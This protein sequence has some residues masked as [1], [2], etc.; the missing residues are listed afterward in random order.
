MPVN[1]FDNY[2][3]AWK[4][5]KSKLSR[6]IYKALAEQMER[7][8]ADGLL[9]PGTKLPPQRELADFL[10]I[11][12]TTVTRA[13]KLCEYKGLIYSV[14]GS[15]TFVSARTAHDASLGGKV[16]RSNVIELG[17][18]ISF[19]ETNMDVIP[20]MH[21]VLAHKY[22]E[23]LLTYREPY[24][25]A[26]QRQAASEWL[27]LLGVNVNY[28]D[29]AIMN[30]ALNAVATTYLTLFNSGERIAVDTFTYSNFIELS[31]LFHLTLVP[32]RSDEQGMSADD[33]EAVCRQTD[34]RGLFLIPSCANPTTTVMSE[35]RKKDIAKVIKKYDLLLIEDDPEAFMTYGYVD[36][37][38]EPLYSMVPDNTIYICSMSKSFCAGVRIAFMIAPPKAQS[39]LELSIFNTNVKTSSLDA[40]IV[41]EAIMTGRAHKMC[42]KRI[43]LAKQANRIYEEIFP[44]APRPGH[45]NPYYRWHPVS[46]IISHSDKDSSDIEKTLLAHGVSVFPSSIYKTDSKAKDDHIRISL[47]SAGSMDK[48]K[49]GLTIVRDVLSNHRPE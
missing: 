23:Q 41:T 14:M 6:P 5:E 48:L 25:M 45:P 36:G 33:L 27:S 46:D 24:G 18:V 22:P 15:G 30:G 2:P 31:K 29:I 20:L 8:I 43:A 21:K 49:Q 35:E 12:F 32:V 26:H 17:P 44:N 19:E 16:F 9:L 38:G 37:C 47:S 3:M 28:S 42:E 39:A 40:E 1:S 10:D 11:N 13:Y 34:I 7:D 4:P